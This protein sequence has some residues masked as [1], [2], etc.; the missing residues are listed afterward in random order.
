MSDCSSDLAWLHCGLVVL[1]HTAAVGVAASHLADAVMLL[2]LTV[3]EVSGVCSSQTQ[4]SA[5]GVLLML[6]LAVAKEI[7][8]K[9]GA[10]GLYKGLSAGLLR[11]AT[12]TTARLGIFQIFSDLLKQQNQ[13]KVHQLSSSTVFSGC[14]F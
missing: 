14:L 11:Q 10:G 6:Q 13:G 7:I 8:A 3:G 1:S 2:S 4:E 12:Y 5:D 9:D